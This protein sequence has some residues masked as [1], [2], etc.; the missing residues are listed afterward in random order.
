MDSAPL[1]PPSNSSG[2]GCI[3]PSGS[4][5]PDLTARIA[6][7]M[8]RWALAILAGLMGLLAMVW[9]ARRRTTG[10]QPA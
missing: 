10:G 4:G 8:G 1:A 6:R 9:Y 3:V 2:R 5:L 7:P